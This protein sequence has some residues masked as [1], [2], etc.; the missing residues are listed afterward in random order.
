MTVRSFL[1]VAVALLASGA[2]AGTLSSATWTTELPPFVA[3]GATLAVAVPVSASGTSASASIAV[4]LTLPPFQ[5]GVFGT[6]GSLQTHRTVTFAG[7][8][9][10][11]ATPSMAAATQGVAGSVIVKGAIHIAK[12]ANASMLTPAMT[13]L[14]R[15]PLGVGAVGS[16]TD[17]FYIS[18]SP[19]Y[20]TVD[21]YGW[22]P[23]AVTVTGLT[24]KLAPIPDAMA[25]GSFDLTAMGGGSVLLVSP[26]R[27]SIDG[28]LAQRRAV[29]FTTLKLDFVPEP[30]TALLLG[31]GGVALLIFH[32]QRS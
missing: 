17:L 18:G 31:A 27:L 4:S 22:Y 15:V 16:A 8:Q 29:F 14:F 23:G 1:A 21:F 5:T 30:G 11:T 2:S 9:M 28:P 12:G 6:G 7:S 3:G 19:Q 10:L 32:R 26:T 24:S 20:V 25:T 13:T